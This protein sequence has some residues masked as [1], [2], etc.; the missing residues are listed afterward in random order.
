MKR[1]YYAEDGK[2]KGPFTEEATR[3]LIARGIIQPSSQLFQEDGSL[4]FDASELPPRR[5]ERPFEKVV[6]R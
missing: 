4:W 1:F 6:K 5:V 3:D 2:M